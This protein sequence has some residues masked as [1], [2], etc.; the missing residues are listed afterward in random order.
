MSKKPS[1]IVSGAGWIG[2][3]VSKLEKALRK[4][5][6]ADEQIHELVKD[7]EAPDS[8]VKKV[9]DVLA[10][11]M[12]RILFTLR[13]GGN[14]TTEQVVAAGH[15][16][17]VNPNITKEKFPMRLRPEGKIEIELLEFDFDPTSEQVLAEAT[18]RG[19]ERP[20]YE[21]ALLFGE[22]HSEEQRKN[23]IV[24]LHEP[25]VSDGFLSVV[26]LCAGGAGRGLGLDWF[27]GRWDRSYRFAFVRRSQ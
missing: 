11:T 24:F 20:M 17:W 12:R 5:G 15:Y 6:V 1:A 10:E 21:D 27:G 19:L 16:D 18:K 7:G 25:Q 13:V 3:F 22:Q 2:S 26:V 23:T 9:A 4:L 8:L 14:R